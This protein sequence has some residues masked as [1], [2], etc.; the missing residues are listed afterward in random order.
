VLVD[1]ASPERLLG[2]IEETCLK[3]ILYVVYKSN[4]RFGE[5]RCARGGEDEVAAAVGLRDL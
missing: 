2:F 3:Q 5:Q 1:E 4:D